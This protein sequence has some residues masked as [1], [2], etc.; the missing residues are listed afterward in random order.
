MNNNDLD[1]LRQRADSD[2][3]TIIYHLNEMWMQLNQKQGINAFEF[4]DEIQTV[5]ASVGPMVIEVPVQGDSPS[6]LLRDLFDKV[7]K[8]V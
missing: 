6:K 2:K 4:D 1:I 7:C 3:H 5:Y 8:Y